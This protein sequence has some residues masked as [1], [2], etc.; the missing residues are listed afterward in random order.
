MSHIIVEVLAGDVNLYEASYE[1]A[2]SLF[3]KYDVID[4]SVKDIVESQSAIFEQD[5]IIAYLNRLINSKHQ[6]LEH[7]AAAVID[8]CEKN[9]I[10][11]RD[12]GKFRAID[13]IGF[14]MKWKPT[15]LPFITKKFPMIQE[16]PAF[17]SFDTY[18]ILK[19][20]SR[21]YKNSW[22]ERMTES[23]KI[24][25]VLDFIADMRP[26]VQLSVK[27]IGKLG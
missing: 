25:F 5:K 2:V 10:A 16:F 27:E 26:E 4:Q 14:F 3:E 12:Y 6:A 22:P 15:D 18:E 21:I 1:G 13:G 19:K 8:F 9:E 17:V 24:N 7:L 20:Y 11:V 23:L